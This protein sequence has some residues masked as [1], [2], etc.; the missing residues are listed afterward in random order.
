MNKKYAYAN[1]KIPVEIK[2]NGKIEPMKEYV[3]IDFSP[4]YN[5]PN[6]KIDNTTILNNLNHLFITLNSLTN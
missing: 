3:Q 5:L 6:K 2:E 4:C 1:I